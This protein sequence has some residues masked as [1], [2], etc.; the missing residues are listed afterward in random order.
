MLERCRHTVKAKHYI[1]AA[2]GIENP[3][4]LL[5][6]NRHQKNGLGNDNDLVGR[7]FMDHYGVK[8]ARFAH[9]IRC[10]GLETSRQPRRPATTAFATP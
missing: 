8:P 1:I 5:L 2:G 4:L 9:G 3:R 10:F 6:S 7:F